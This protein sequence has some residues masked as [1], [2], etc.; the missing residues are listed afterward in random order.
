MVASSTVTV[1][2]VKDEMRQ[3]QKIEPNLAK[4]IKKDFKEIVKPVVG[5]SI[6]GSQLAVVR[7]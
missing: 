5:C 7:I 6:T 3:L 1:V 2:G 4:Q